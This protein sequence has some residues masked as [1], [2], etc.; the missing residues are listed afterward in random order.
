M[1]GKARDH[2]LGVAF[3][4]GDIFVA[5][6]RSDADLDQQRRVGRMHTDRPR[7]HQRDRS[8]WSASARRSSSGL[9]PEQMARSACRHDGDRLLVRADVPALADLCVP[10]AREFGQGG[11]A[12]IGWSSSSL[13]STSTAVCSPPD[14]SW[15]PI[16]RRAACC[17]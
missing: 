6:P 2:L 9:T 7:T 17:S 16:V 1:K 3:D 14:D 12:S 11:I 5:R 8:P 4:C 10:F 13:A 15:R